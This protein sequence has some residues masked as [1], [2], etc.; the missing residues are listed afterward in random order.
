MNNSLYGLKPAGYNWFAKLRSTW[1]LNVGQRED[2]LD[3][4][5]VLTHLVKVADGLHFLLLFGGSFD[6]S[7]DLGTACT[8]LEIS[9]V[10]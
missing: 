3:L 7:A 10:A 8:I 1:T 9:T 5:K 4:V 6:L 2:R